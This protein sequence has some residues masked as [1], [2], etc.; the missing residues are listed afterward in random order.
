MYNSYHFWRRKIFVA[1][2]TKPQSP[3]KDGDNFFGGN[4]HTYFVFLRFSSALPQ[5]RIYYLV[6]FLMMTSLYRIKEVWKDEW[7]WKWIRSGT[8]WWDEERKLNLENLYSMIAVWW[9]NFT[10]DLIMGSVSGN[11]N[12]TRDL[13]ICRLIIQTWHGEDEFPGKRFWSCLVCL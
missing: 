13:K 11:V 8:Y 6:V 7:K 1:R 9:Q 4:Y 5:C 3:N 12:S 10:S 2:S